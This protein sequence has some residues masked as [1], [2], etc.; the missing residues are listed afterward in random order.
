[1]DQEKDYSEFG[2]LKILRENLKKHDVTCH[3]LINSGNISPFTYT[4]RL[5]LQETDILKS[6]YQIGN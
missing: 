5:F 6:R 4:P 1:M 3:P 2:P